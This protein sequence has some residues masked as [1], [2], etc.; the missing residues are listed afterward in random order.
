MVQGGKGAL[1]LENPR[2][3]LSWHLLVLHMKNLEGAYE[4]DYFLQVGSYTQH[5]HKNRLNRKGFVQNTLRPE[6]TCNLLLEWLLHPNMVLFQRIPNFE[7]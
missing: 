2:R 1:C 5:R 6:S 4:H 7:V 3:A